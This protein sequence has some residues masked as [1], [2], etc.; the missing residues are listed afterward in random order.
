M[1]KKGSSSLKPVVPELAVADEWLGWVADN[2][3]AGAAVEAVVAELEVR[4]VPALLVQQVVEA[5]QLSPVFVAARRHAL[6]GRRLELMR[7]LLVEQ[8][9]LEFNRFE[10][11]RRTACDA[12]EFFGGYVATN[13][14]VV[15]T[16][17]VTRWLGFGRWSPEDFAARFGE[18][19]LDVAQGREAEPNYDQLTQRLSQKM[20][21]RALAEAVRQ[22]ESSNDFY[23]VAQNK[24]IHQPGLQ[25]LFEEMWFPE[26]WLDDAHFFG[27]AALWLGPK[28][29]ITPLHHDTSNILFCQVYGKKHFTL[30]SPLEMELSEDATSMYA[31]LDPESPEG[32]AWLAGR[33]VKHVE[34][35]AGEA[36]FIPAGY[37]HHVRALSVSISVA[38]NNLSQ[39]NNFDWYR[40]GQER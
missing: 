29:T 21:M 39:P 5:L 22:V 20:S 1:A 19:L 37:W 35:D 30:V 7:R 3:L 38:A 32:Q 26:G 36:L 24:N 11:E 12:R 23:A 8:R 25:R 6:R 2:L 9:Q 13:T 15:F 27:A 10:V 17:L 16:D 34:L 31:A 28:G 18:V 4:G 14:P 33:L 40:P